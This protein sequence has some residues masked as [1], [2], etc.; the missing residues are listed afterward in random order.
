MGSV[1]RVSTC[2]ESVKCMWNV[3]LSSVSALSVEQLSSAGEVSVDI[4]SPT[5]LQYTE[6]DP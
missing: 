4:L 5:S 1:Y 3:Y 6:Q 2:D